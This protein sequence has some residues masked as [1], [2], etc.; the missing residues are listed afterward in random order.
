MHEQLDPDLVTYGEI[1]P[2]SGVSQVF[3]AGIA[4]PKLFRTPEIGAG[5]RTARYYLA[6]EIARRFESMS[7]HERLLLHVAT[8]K[9]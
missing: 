2:R 4:V 6:I 1:E 5:A 9:A 7:A 3:Y 8:Q